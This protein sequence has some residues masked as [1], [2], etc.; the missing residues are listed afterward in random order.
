M[1]CKKFEEV[2]DYCVLIEYWDHRFCDDDNDDDDGD[3]DECIDAM[4]NDK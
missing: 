2:C 1:I 3:G 4:L